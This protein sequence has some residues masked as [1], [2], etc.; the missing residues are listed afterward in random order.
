MQ[1]KRSKKI[2]LYF[3]LFLIIGTL[4]NK[5]LNS[6]NFTKINSI[7][8]NGLDA[9]NNLKLKNNLNF[10]K[11]YNIFFFEKTILKKLLD[12][13]SLVENYSVSKQYPSVLY[14]KIDKTKILAKLKKNGKDFYLGSNG[15]LIEEDEIKYQVPF[16]F[17]NFKIK[18]FLQLIEIINK[19][20]FDYNKVDKLFFF[21]SGRWDVQTKDGLLIRLPNNNIIE[22]FE[23]LEKFLNDKNNKE[24]IKIDLRQKNQVIINDR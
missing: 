10:L 8:V 1:Q 6:I 3:F 22:S 18:N 17:G 5:N 21:K 15:K 24:I 13:N 12:G 7:E 14:I 4:N 11:E 16:I 23:L 9:K 19:T 2:L 20:N